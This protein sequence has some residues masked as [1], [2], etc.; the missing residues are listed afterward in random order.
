LV[1]WQD[2]TSSE[3]SSDGDNDHPLNDWQTVFIVLGSLVGAC[4][5]LGVLA[6]VGVFVYR[7]YQRT[8]KDYEPL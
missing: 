5:V 4:L 6:V 1:P 7:H 2:A 8:K 3:Y